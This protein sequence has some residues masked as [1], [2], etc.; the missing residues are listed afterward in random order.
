MS[1]WS[2]QN[3]SIGFYQI[4]SHLQGALQPLTIPSAEV[5]PEDEFAVESAKF[6]RRDRDLAA[7]LVYV[8]KAGPASV[9]YLIPPAK[10]MPG[11]SRA[12]T[13]GLPFHSFAARVSLQP[14]R[15]DSFRSV[16]IFPVYAAAIHKFSAPFFQVFGSS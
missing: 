1:F 6:W 5:I 12:W 15:I 2:L 9:D 13:E 16:S 11:M 14:S 7:L 8:R 4:V 3:R 10:F